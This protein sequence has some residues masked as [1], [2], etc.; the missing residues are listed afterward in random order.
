LLEV[1]WVDVLEG[2]PLLDI[3]PYLS[4]FETRENVLDDWL[5]TASEIDKIRR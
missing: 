1:S 3:K 4:L 5:G 2:T